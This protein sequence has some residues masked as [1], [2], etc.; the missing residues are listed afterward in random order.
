MSEGNGPSAQQPMPEGQHAP[1]QPSAPT[2]NGPAPGG[3]APARPGNPGG[4][5]PAACGPP[6]HSDGA[7]GA[8]PRPTLP[9]DM[10]LPW[11]ATADRRDLWGPA[12]KPLEGKVHSPGSASTSKELARPRRNP[13]LSV[14]VPLLSGSA[15]A[16]A[17]AALGVAGVL[18]APVA[19]IAAIGAGVVTAGG[20]GGILYSLRPTPSPLLTSGVDIPESTREVLEQI[21]HATAETRGRTRDLRTSTS[22]PTSLQVLEHVD[23]LLARID[24]LAGSESI[25]TLR[26][27]A[28]EVTMLE[29]MATRYVPEL[30]DAAE[31]TIGFL[32]T[33]RGDARRDA[34]ENLRSVD[35]QLTVLG[36]GI[37]RIE[38]DMVAGVSR[39]LE[40]H[41]EFLRTRF[42][43]QHLNPII[44]V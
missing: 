9:G 44:D 21:L 12:Q 25:Q 38:Q 7:G 10:D 20:T 36:D 15:A 33:F 19:V 26:P 8:P 5:A 14:G 31:D 29:G 16:F 2:H 27:S 39:S 41:S 11:K 24:A 13:L 43:D 1:S 42:A 28:G 34:Q 4:D 23:S 30:V 17:V 32:A 6:A 18:A 35:Q 40:V 22:D 3:D 37:E